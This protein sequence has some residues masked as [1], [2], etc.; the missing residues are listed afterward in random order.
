MD[1]TT[2]EIDLTFSPACD[3]TDHTVYYGDLANVSTYGYSGAACFLGNSGVA[4]FDP[5]PGSR[6]FLIVGNTGVV[7]GSYGRD[8][9]GF[10]RPE[11]FSGTACDLSQ[12]LSSVCD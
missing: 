9:A 4:S 3:A 1:A 6:F 12:D 7:E 8:G 5:G 10:E 11:H 2:G